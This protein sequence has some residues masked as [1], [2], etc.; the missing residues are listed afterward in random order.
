VSTTWGGVVEGSGFAG[1]GSD[2]C[3]AAPLGPSSG[4]GVNLSVKKLRRSATVIGGSFLGLGL[5]A[6]LATPAL[7]C[8]S[9][10]TGVVSCVNADGTWSVAWSVSS[11]ETDVPGT[12]IGVQTTPADAS[13]TNIVVNTANP[14]PIPAQGQAPLTGIETLKATDTTASLHIDGSYFYNGYAHAVKADSESFS[15]PEKECTSSS[16]PPSTPPTTLP[17]TTPP[18]TPATTT[19][20]PTPTVT[21]PETQPVFLYNDTCTT[22]SVGLVVPKTWKKAE[23]VTF[24]PSTGTAKSITVKPG[25]TKFVDFPAS[26]NLYVEATAKSYPNDKL[27]ISY[28]A[29]ANCT[30]A[31][32]S[33]GPAL[34]VT[35]S[36]SAP[37]AGG[38]VALVLVGGG[39]F[40][41]ARRRKMKFT[42]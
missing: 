42:A 9:T 40:F 35:G 11:D 20:T 12:I 17:T 33:S 41:M 27:K 30:S 23:T 32:P 37:L 16:T 39:A 13:L 7:A 6:A 15:K 3:L 1:L 24:T 14:V 36:S 25:E 34:P 22:F 4:V 5:A 10:I 18:T 38:A 8:N 21:A 28:K 31:S 26:K 19:P 2:F 29:P